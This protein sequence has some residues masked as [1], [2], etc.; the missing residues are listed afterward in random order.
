MSRWRIGLR[1]IPCRMQPRSHPRK[2]SARSRLAFAGSKMWTWIFMPRP[3][4][5]PK[6]F[7]FSTRVRP[8]DIIIRT[9]VPPQG[10]SMSLLNLKGRWISGNWKRQL[11]SIKAS[12]R[13]AP[14]GR[15]ELNLRASYP[16]R[17]FQLKLRKGPRQGRGQSAGILGAFADSGDIKA[18]TRD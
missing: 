2:W 17:F 3:N 4:R 15:Y 1:A 18:A 10:G 7:S 9:I 14:M 5:E 8:K 12:G 11:I 13:A 16:A 6:R